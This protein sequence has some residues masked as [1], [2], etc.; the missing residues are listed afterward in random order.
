MGRHCKKQ[1]T[2]KNLQF[3]SSQRLKEDSTDITEDRQESWSL[4]L[5]VLRVAQVWESTCWWTMDQLCRRAH[6][7]SDNWFRNILCTH[8]IFSH[9][10]VLIS[11]VLSNTFLRTV[12]CRTLC[13]SPSQPEKIKGN[14]IPTWSIIFSNGNI[15]TLKIKGS[16]YPA[17]E[18]NT[19]R[20]SL[21]QRLQASR[22]WAVWNQEHSTLMLG[23][24]VLF[25]C[26]FHFT[27]PVQLDYCPNSGKSI[28]L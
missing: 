6:L 12:F 26:L 21:L 7:A 16:Y 17:F 28:M 4:I 5:F 8:N 1:I 2:L 25:C 23:F 27:I 13:F 11:S 22:G 18:K 14:L 20:N 3:F 24:T 15:P 9:R 10:F 19:E